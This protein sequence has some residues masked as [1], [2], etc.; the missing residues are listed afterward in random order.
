MDNEEKHDG[1]TFSTKPVTKRFKET[2]KR[3]RRERKG[4]VGHRPSID[5]AQDMHRISEPFG[6]VVDYVGTDMIF[7]LLEKSR[8]GQ[9]LFEGAGR[10][11]MIFDPQTIGAQYYPKEHL[12][13]LHPHRMK[14]ELVHLFI[15]ELR[16]AWHKEQG[17]LANPLEFDPDGAILV[18]RAQAAD[19]FMM[20]VRVSWELKLRDE[21]EAWDYL[22]RSPMGDIGRIFENHAQTDFRTLNNG[23]AARAA[24]DKWFDDSR[25][26]I[27]D[28]RVIH[29]MLLDDV[30]YISSRK[31]LK[32]AD[33]VLL[34]RVGDQPFGVNY[35]S[36]SGCKSPV[37]R[38]YAAVDDRSNAN[39]LWFV[40]FERSFQEKERQMVEAAV[41]AS[42]EVVDF[43]RKLKESSEKKNGPSPRM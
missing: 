42:A 5:W 10:P 27:A 19:A 43:A 13:A 32:K 38:D 36:I 21:P 29:Q 26:K 18:N 39:F 12:I 37:D 4:R 31:E 17:T 14:A 3:L 24:Y 11:K 6:D 41:K 8:T 1:V 7:N 34:A 20:A 25:T 9:A 2:T 30:G 28:K 22:I 35:L 40:K 16:R 33:R 23:V 15:R